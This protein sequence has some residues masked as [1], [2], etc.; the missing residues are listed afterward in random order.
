MLIKQV[1]D[2]MQFYLSQ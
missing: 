1:H 2:P